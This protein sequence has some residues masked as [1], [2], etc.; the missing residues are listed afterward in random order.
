ME[1]FSGIVPK[2]PQLN[3]GYSKT[4][5]GIS[6][7]FNPGQKGILYCLIKFA[8][9]YLTLKPNVHNTHEIILSHIF[10]C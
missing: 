10:F 7:M 2:F 4:I 1:P 6:P 5:P 8:K 9:I 3:P